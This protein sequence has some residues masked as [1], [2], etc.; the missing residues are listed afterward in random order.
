[1]NELWLR[2]PSLEF[3]HSDTP[4]GCSLFVFMV[5]SF[6]CRFASENATLSFAS[7]NSGN[8][9][10]VSKFHSL[11]LFFDSSSGASH[12][13]ICC[14]RISLRFFRISKLGLLRFF[15]EISGSSLYFRNFMFF[16]VFS[17]SGGFL[18]IFEISMF[19]G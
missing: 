19:W 6:A 13:S 18:C 9:L 15:F 5:L 17:K 4:R 11:L 12:L 1:M 3:R 16:I 8:R 10:S 7:R 14:F 2:M